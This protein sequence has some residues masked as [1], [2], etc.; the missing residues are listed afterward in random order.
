MSR[1]CVLGWQLMSQGAWGMCWM[2]VIGA[3]E[4]ESDNFHGEWVGMSFPFLTY[5]SWA[6]PACALCLGGC[7]QYPAQHGRRQNPS[8]FLGKSNSPA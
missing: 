5:G 4:A 7:S 3:Q 1:A 8:F 2:G 6:D